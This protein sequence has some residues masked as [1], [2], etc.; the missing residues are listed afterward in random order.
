MKFKEIFL[1]NKDRRYR[2]IT[3]VKKENI[4]IYG[5]LQTTPKE[6]ALANEMHQ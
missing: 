6:E 4:T 3:K 5:Q 2:N 1:E